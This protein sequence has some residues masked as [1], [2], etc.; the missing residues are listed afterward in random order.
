M[1]AQYE[2]QTGIGCYGPFPPVIPEKV[3]YNGANGGY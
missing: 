1:N 3:C 2:H